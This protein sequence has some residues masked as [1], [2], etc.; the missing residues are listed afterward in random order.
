M[1]II[2]GLG[3]KI[4]D[5]EEL[6]KFIKKYKLDQ[7]TFYRLKAHPGTIFSGKKEMES[8]DYVEWVK[9]TRTEFPRLKIVVGSWLGHLDEVSLL[10]KAGADN[11]TKFPALK[12]FGNK[13]AQQIEDEVKKAGRKLNGSLTKQP[14]INWG[15]KIKKLNVPEDLKEHIK[16]KLKQY[17]NMMKKVK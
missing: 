3:E 10:L 17:L 13:Y 9:M 8:K 15:Q 1:T 14:K 5:F 12:M 11:V 2:L 4:D 7:V 16:L 6:K